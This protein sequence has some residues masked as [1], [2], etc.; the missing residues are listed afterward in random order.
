M[1]KANINE[2][3]D[4]LPK[5]PEGVQQ[6]FKNESYRMNSYSYYDILTDP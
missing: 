3:S 4:L 1:I 6:Y 5:F 2:T